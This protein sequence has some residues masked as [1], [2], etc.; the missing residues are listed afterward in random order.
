[1]FAAGGEK[2]ACRMGCGIMKI[3]T[4]ER[5]STGISVQQKG[6]TVVLL[7]ERPKSNE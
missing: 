2:N 6:S 1:M 4:D 3:I 5:L 7:K